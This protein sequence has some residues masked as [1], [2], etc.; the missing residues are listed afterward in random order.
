[1]FHSKSVGRV[2]DIRFFRLWCS[3][4]VVVHLNPHDQGFDSLMTSERGTNVSNRATM[5]SARTVTVPLL[6][7][8]F[9]LRSF[10]LVKVDIEG[11]EKD[12]FKPVSKYG[13]RDS[14]PRQLLP[15]LC[16]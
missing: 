11:A 2:V 4:E 7:S 3:V 13:P 6:L 16:P 10:D 9:G 1:M 8:M 14:S 12:V 15:I 5:G